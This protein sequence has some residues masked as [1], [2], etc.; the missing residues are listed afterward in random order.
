MSSEKRV[1]GEGG[2]GAQDASVVTPSLEGERA[3]RAPPTHHHHHHY[4]SIYRPSPPPH[5]PTTPTLSVT[6]PHIKAPRA[7]QVW[8]RAVWRLESVELA[9]VLAVK[10]GKP[11]WAGTVICQQH[12]LTLPLLLICI[13]TTDS[14][15]GRLFVRGTKE[16]IHKDRDVWNREQCRGSSLPY[17]HVLRSGGRCV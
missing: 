4:S 14:V 11:S 2:G 10:Q 6:L 15:G 12:I 3:E 8:S 7:G 1:G 17:A 5:P 16:M 13:C 9:G